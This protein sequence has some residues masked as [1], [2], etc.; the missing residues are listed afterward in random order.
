MENLF[1]I[2]AITG[3]VVLIIQLILFLIGA[4]GDEDTDFDSE[5]DGD[6]DF[7]VGS[8]FPFFTF[9]SLVGFIGGFGWS[10]IIAMEQTESN[11]II[12]GSS[13]FTGIVFALIVSSLLFMI[14]KLK[15]SGN[16]KIRNAMNKTGDVYLPIPGES[17]GTGIVQV[18]VQ[19]TLTDFK[20]LTRGES[21]KTGSRIK[22]MS[23]EGNVLIVEKI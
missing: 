14:S 9:K 8:S 11:L 4:G 7:D 2:F 20:A 16:I 17:K 12:F 15:H 6:N 21:I 23:I 10:G 18:V 13:I 5:M 3:S 19:D 1:W 22:V